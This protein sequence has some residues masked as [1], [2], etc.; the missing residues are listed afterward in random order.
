ME[1]RS[2]KVSKPEASEMNC[3]YCKFLENFGCVVQKVEIKFSP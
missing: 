3:D 2:R 1:C